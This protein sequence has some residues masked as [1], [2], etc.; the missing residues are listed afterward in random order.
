M[1][2]FDKLKGAAATLADAAV[3][4]TGDLAQKGKKQ[5]ALL[6]LPILP[7]LW[8]IWHARRHEFP[9]E[10]EK[11]WWTLGAVVVPLR[12]GLAYLLF[13]LRRGKSAAGA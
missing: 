12:G 2:T 7:N 10:R 4:T 9:G 5:M 1:T 8:A 13:G 11:Y 3:K 6:A